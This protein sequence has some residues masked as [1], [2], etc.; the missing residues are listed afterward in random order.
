[1]RPTNQPTKNLGVALLGAFS[2]IIPDA[3]SH[4]LAAPDIQTALLRLADR[5]KRALPNAK[6]IL[7]LPPVDHHSKSVVKLA[8]RLK[9]KGV[10]IHYAHNFDVVARLISVCSR[11]RLDRL[12]RLRITDL[13]ADTSLMRSMA[14]A[15]EQTGADW[16]ACPQAANGSAGFLIT[17]PALRHL[18]A[19]AA[20]EKRRV[21]FSERKQFAQ[22]LRLL[23]IPPEP[24]APRAPDIDLQIRELSDAPFCRQAT[25]DKLWDAPAAL[26]AARAKYLDRSQFD[27]ALPSVLSAAAARVRSF[28]AGHETLLIL[29]SH[30]LDE[31]QKQRDHR[32]TEQ[33]RRHTRILYFEPQLPTAT[34]PVSLFTQLNSEGVA[35]NQEHLGQ[36]VDNACSEQGGVL[37][38]RAPEYTGYDLFSA[39]HHDKI[40]NY[41]NA[42]VPRL[43]GLRVL[44]SCPHY[45]PVVASLPRPRSLVYDCH[46]NYSHFEGAWLYLDKVEAELAKHASTVVVTAESLRAKLAPHNR[47]VVLIPNGVELARF[48]A[49]RPRRRPG[50]TVTLGYVGII[51]HWFD[52]RLIRDVA[53]LRPDWNIRLTGPLLYCDVSSLRRCP[54]IHFVGPKPNDAVPAELERL[55]ICLIPFKINP[56]TEAVDP[57]KLYEYFAAQRPVVSAPLPE[58]RQYLRLPT[59]RLSGTA[60]GVVEAVEAI[61]ALP[62]DERLRSLS[63]ASAI[64]KSR[65]WPLLAD[66]LWNEALATDHPTEP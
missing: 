65:D 50:T 41:L 3:A 20:Q 44:V 11:H 27:A 38:L 30:A 10:H 31:A 35:F 14:S 2:P 48:A 21:F 12:L 29:G 8:E 39:R 40:A 60:Q 47:D 46:D 42:V 58:L 54:N 63:E 55:D 19:T 61:L 26:A 23:D 25:R 18:A 24:S 16:V 59:L 33:L 6:I 62:Q 51:G 17:L 37:R 45:G 22:E 1:M 13:A 4:L 64:A 7:A 32:L 43:P 36:L 28:A 9:A 53:R 5:I 49:S 34:A 57:V 52:I 15:Q 66:R 56:L